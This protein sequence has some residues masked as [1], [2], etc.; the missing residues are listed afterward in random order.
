[1]RKWLERTFGKKQPKETPAEVNRKTM[2]AHEKHRNRFGTETIM[3][4][5]KHWDR[6]EIHPEFFP[7]I[8]DSKKPDNPEFKRIKKEYALLAFDVVEGYYQY[9]INLSGLSSRPD[10]HKTLKHVM[11]EF[12]VMFWDMPSSKDNHH[13]HRF[14]HL[15]HSLRVA[16]KSA[17]AGESFK[18]Y[19]ESGINTES[20][21]RDKG[22]IILSHF[23]VGLFHD[24]HKL[25]DYKLTHQTQ[26]R[27]VEWSPHLG[28][29]LN[30]KLVH[31]QNLYEDWEKLPQDTSH[32]SIGYMF[33]MVPPE[34]FST[35]ES[36]ELYRHIMEKMTA[37]IDSEIAGDHE[38]AADGLRKDPQQK[39]YLGL[40]GAVMDLIEKGHDKDHVYQVSDDWCAVMFKSFTTNVA[41]RSAVFPNDAA[42]IHYMDHLGIVASPYSDGVPKFSERHNFVVKDGPAKGKRIKKCGLTF[43]SA[44]FFKSLTLQI[45]REQNVQPELTRIQIER[46]VFSKESL[47][48]GL[49]PPL[50]EDSYCLAPGMEPEGVEEGSRAA[51]QSQPEQTSS[52]DNQQGKSTPKVEPTA[53]QESNGS[54]G[55]NYNQ[56]VENDEQ[57]KSGQGHIHST[58]ISEEEL[59]AAGCDVPMDEAPPEADPAANTQSAYPPLTDLN[60]QGTRLDP[61]LAAVAKAPRP[62]SKTPPEKPD[63]EQDIEVAPL[64]DAPDEVMTVHGEMLDARAFVARCLDLLNEYGI[65]TPEKPLALYIT[66]GDAANGK[67]YLKIPDIFERV[68]GMHNMLTSEEGPDALLKTL[69][70]L[71]KKSTIVPLGGEMPP[72]HA[73]LTYFAVEDILSEEPLTAKNFMAVELVET[74]KAKR[75]LRPL[76][77][78]IDYRDMEEVVVE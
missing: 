67:L 38:D 54:Q 68:L 20:M 73:Q 37:L 50:P 18:L 30:F 11:L 78:Y 61:E 49:I 8:D 43:V 25:F 71:E 23:F 53:A 64:P 77:E 72:V 66:N 52:K 48:T 56:P 57:E 26:Y 31:P 3:T 2:Q 16:C 7:K 5:T 33:W 47:I 10:L 6:I 1:M 69:S 70:V 27:K 32:Y 24:A 42:V 36:S 13:S 29:V 34:F 40:T 9:V 21:N 55:D 12:I 51:S 19:T 75:T 35:I 63:H 74:F 15:L 60:P 41:R 28:S 76:R 58:Q 46:T 45:A 44:E 4:R 65:N 22:H 62:D 39:M 59:M 17:E 14:G